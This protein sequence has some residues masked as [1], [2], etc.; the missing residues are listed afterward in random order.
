MRAP[1]SP[2]RGA[3]MS[4]K[5]L[6]TFATPGPT[7][8]SRTAIT[9]GMVDV[10]NARCRPKLLS[11]DPRVLQLVMAAVHRYMCSV[12][13]MSRLGRLRVSSNVCHAFPDMRRWQIAACKNSS[14]GASN[15][16]SVPS[17]SAVLSMVVRRRCRTVLTKKKQHRVALDSTSFRKGLDGSASHTARTSSLACAPHGAFSMRTTA[18]KPEN[19]VNAC[20]ASALSGV[21]GLASG[22]AWRGFLSNRGCAAS[23]PESGVPRQ[24][25]NAQNAGRRPSAHLRPRPELHGGRSC[26]STSPTLPLPVR[27]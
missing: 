16:L 21:T 27:N 19:A 14:V 8:T 9:R 23:C 26:Y 1:H 12:R 24:A 11:S 4:S 18:Q 6:G 13:A 25:P 17:C 7:P 3:S 15:R 5:L 22:T 20:S 10:K 2:Q